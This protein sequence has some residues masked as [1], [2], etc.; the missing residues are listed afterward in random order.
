MPARSTGNYP[1]KCWIYE[2]QD[3]L[4]DTFL[5]SVPGVRWESVHPVEFAKNHAAT[6]QH[7]LIC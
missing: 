7:V 6:D 5:E 4:A 3:L 2:G 1:F